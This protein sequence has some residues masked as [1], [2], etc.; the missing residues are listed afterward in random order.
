MNPTP[1]SP[2]G[3]NIL[4]LNDSPTETTTAIEPS[5]D[6]VTEAIPAFGSV[7]STVPIKTFEDYQGKSKQLA[8]DHALE[9]ST[10]ACLYTVGREGRQD[11]YKQVWEVRKGYHFGSLM[12]Y[13]NGAA[14]KDRLTLER[15]AI[16]TYKAMYGEDAI[17]EFLPVLTL[18]EHREF[19]HRLINASS[20]LV[21][22]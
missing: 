15:S 4:D 18:D 22:V 11:S 12:N 19:R 21:C 17:A 3:I 6:D 5:T 10:D 13:Y 9:L 20:T 14:L 8:I 1:N 16:A 2:A 7:E